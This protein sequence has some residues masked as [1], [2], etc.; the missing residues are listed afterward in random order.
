MHS[1]KYRKKPRILYF[2]TNGTVGGA[3]TH[4]YHLASSLR[5]VFDLHVAMGSRGELWRRLE[6]Q[7][8][9]V[10][11]IPWLVRNVSPANDARSLFEIVRLIKAL[12][13]DLVSLH[14]SKSGLLGR[15]AARICGVPS[16]F[17]A[18]GWAFSEGVPENRRKLYL[19][20]ERIAARW[21][22]KVICVSEYD[23]RLA[24]RCIAG[25]ERRLITIHNGI[26]G[27]GPEYLADPGPGYPVRLI[28]VARFSEPKDHKLLLRVL[29]DMPAGS[30]F[31]LDLVGDGPL[32]SECKELAGRLELN[33]CVSFLGDR[34][35]VQ[36]LLAKAQI[37]ILLSKWEGLPISILEAMRAGLPVIA[38]DVGGA[39]EAVADRE[40]GFLIPRGDSAALKKRLVTLLDDPALRALMGVNGRKRFLKNFTLDQMIEKTAAVYRDAAEGK[41]NFRAIE[42]AVAEEL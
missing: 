29:S 10:Y 6:S 37:F 41:R 39:G 31:H 14:S 35:D 24:G 17:T 11:H 4:L 18:H 19:M 22:Q 30:C 40:T 8:V 3:Q 15:L 12:G 26:P 21:A 28:M 34:A 2:I 20:A 36:E 5:G 16:V 32:L 42:N 27:G 1:A 9:R 25:D 38:S 23:R 13:P 33:N 7:A